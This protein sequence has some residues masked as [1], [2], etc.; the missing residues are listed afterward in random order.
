MNIEIEKKWL[1]KR[2]PA[3]VPLGTSEGFQSYPSV[4]PAIRV[5]RKVCHDTSEYYLTLKGKGSISR[6]EFELPIS[7]EDY[8]NIC[9][10]LLFGMKPIHKE[11]HYYSLDSFCDSNILADPD[12]QLR[13]DVVDRGATSEFIYAEVEFKSVDDA[14]AFEF[15]FPECEAVDVTDNPKWKMSNY[16]ERT[17]LIKN[18]HGLEA[19]AMLDDI[20]EMM[21]YP[22][23]DRKLR[24]DDGIRRVS[25][26]VYMVNDGKFIFQYTVR[27]LIID[28]ITHCDLDMPIQ[29]PDTTIR[30]P[31]AEFE[32]DTYG[33]PRFE[34]EF[35]T[36]SLKTGSEKITA[37]GIE[38]A[39]DRAINQFNGKQLK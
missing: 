25:G 32:Y 30:L 28:L 18:I 33:P 12:E 16:W 20:S 10:E 14:R 26:A 3:C 22:E 6:A 37:K 35:T 34:K 9:H 11:N 7:K 36:L 4:D 31:Y 38:E 2:M 19:R 21:Y 15:P 27:D 1:L 13:I 29:V 8:D 39:Y 5:G 24:D 17:R 23:M